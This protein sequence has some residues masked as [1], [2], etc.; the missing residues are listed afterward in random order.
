MIAT[1]ISQLRLPLASLLV[2]A[3]MAC[4]KP[5]NQP[6]APETAAPAPPVTATPAPDRGQQ[7]A[8]ESATPPAEEDALSHVDSGETERAASK[9]GH[10]SAGEPAPGN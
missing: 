10:E 2:L 3:C 7:P 8:G 5:D 9:R 1:K 6:A 4:N